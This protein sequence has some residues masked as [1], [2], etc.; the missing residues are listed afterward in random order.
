MTASHGWSFVDQERKREI[1]EAIRSGAATRGPVHA[2]LDLTD[3]CNVAC[4]FCNQMDVRTRE[5]IPLEKVESILDELVAGGLKSVRLSGGGDP[6]MYPAFAQVQRALAE[7]S[8]T[9]D[10]LTTNGALLTEEIA[11][12]LVDNRAREVIFSL[13]GADAR[14]YQRMM[15]VKGSIFDRVVAA[16]ETLVRL[17]GESPLPTIIV[18]F[19]LDGANYR[20]LPAMYQL[21]RSLGVDRITL[22]AVLEIP[23]ER[24]DTA[25]L[26]G[27]HDHSLVRPYLER[28]LEAD[29]G[30][31]LLQLCFSWPE[32]NQ[33][34]E[35]MK[36]ALAGKASSGGDP[37]GE[38]SRPAPTTGAPLAGGSP[39]G[40]PAEPPAGLAPL[41]EDIDHCFFG[42]YTAAIR[43]TGEMYPCCMLMSP[44]Y[45]PLGNAL[46]G[47]VTAQWQG[48]GFSRLRRE[49]REVFLNGGR[50]FRRRERLKTLRPQCIE[51]HRCG[52]KNMYFREDREF[53]RQLEEAVDEMRSREVRWLGP[54]R[55]VARSGEILA[56][57]TFHGTL[58]RTR[59][60]WR[61]LKKIGMNIM[62]EIEQRPKL[63][64]GCGDKHLD[65]W[66]NIDQQ[67]LP[68]VDVVA[69]VTKGLK[70]SNVEAVY[71]EHFLEHLPIAAALDFMT[72]SHRVLGEDGVM[73]LSTPNLD[74]VWLTHYRLE[75]SDGEKSA[76]AVNLNRAFHGWEHRF[77]WNREM[78]A[79]ALAAAGFV[80][81]TWHRY[82]E[83]SRAV[84]RGL[85]R[86]ET[87]EDNP[88]LPH[89]L[90]VE[91]RK[92]PKQGARLKAL[93]QE[94]QDNFLNHMKG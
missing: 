44:D 67:A 50:M 24:L 63:H 23:N 35:G 51:A 52:L 8:V 89:V 46:E 81:L 39:E 1:I 61:R 66:I 19:L 64:L 86:H 60:V 20:K 37:P 59:A 56:Y 68:G 15:R 47:G 9:I 16:I 93:R 25:G 30:A 27:P 58:V 45:E 4:Y 69:D 83:S 90:I 11:R 14:D 42:W 31:D 36:A 40:E 77:L 34:I 13:N 43:G 79:K 76:M 21:G 7:R 82:G 57:R 65:G 29:Q 17:R 80:D 87:Y 10:N 85:E 54:P 74:W 49:M 41:R 12:S 91:A 28:V 2:E 22:N 92:G 73:R 18:Q 32:W 6:L 55:S 72:E 33:A 94:I 5:S 3:R 26:L 88:E 75:A 84:F 70:F 53:Y 38:I 71:A 48:K 78:L 62:P